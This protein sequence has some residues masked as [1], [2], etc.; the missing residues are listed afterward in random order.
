MFLTDVFM[1]DI[2]TALF[3]SKARVRVLRLFLLNP[4]TQFTTAAIAER[5]QIAS[6][7][8]QR[9]MRMLERIDFVKVRR[10]KGR[11]HYRANDDFALRDQLMTLLTHATVTPECQALTQVVKIG[12]VHLALVSGMF[13]NYTKARADLFIVA[14]DVSRTRLTK[15]I[16]ALEAEMGREVRYVLLTMEEYKYRLNMTDRFLRDFLQG[17]YD[18]IINTLPHFKRTTNALKRRRV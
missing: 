11:K 8:V 17:P 12:E 14:N 16:K 9:E 2:L 1:T 15:W 4:D 10:L 6:V 13:L 5:T 3:G 7:D 18:E